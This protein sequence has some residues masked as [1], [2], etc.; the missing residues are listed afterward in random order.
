VALNNRNRD[1][2]RAGTLFGLFLIWW[3]AGRAVLEFFRPDQVTV[4]DSPITY[5]FLLALGLAI[6]GI[7]VVLRR[8]NRRPEVFTRRRRRQLKPKPRREA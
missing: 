7:W 2:W 1:K 4:G 8:N 3:G 5:S 6:A